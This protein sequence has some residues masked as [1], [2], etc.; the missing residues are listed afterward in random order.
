[1]AISAVFQCIGGVVINILK[2]VIDELER[3]Q[4]I[5]AASIAPYYV[6]SYAC[7]AFS[8]INQ[9]TEAYTEGGMVSKLRMH[10]LFLC[11]PGFG[12]TYMLRQMGDPMYG[13]FG[14]T[15]FS[16]QME[17]NMTE[18][19]LVGSIRMRPD[20]GTEILEGA[21]Y[22]HQNGF[23]LIDEFSAIANAMKQSF[24][25]QLETQ[26][27]TSLDSG[28]VIK[29]LSNGRI[30]YETNFT[31]WAGVQPVKCDLS[32]GLGRRLFSIL[33]LPDDNMRLRYLNGVQ[34]S[35]NIDPGVE[36]LHR[37]RD[38]INL[39]TNSFSMVR[40]ITVDP[41]VF[42]FYREIKAN[43]FDAIMYNR[44][45]LGLTLAR[46]GVS[47][48]INLVFDNVDDMKIIKKQMMWRRMII[49]GPEIHQV[50]NLILNHGIWNGNG[51]VAIN[52]NSLI[53]KGS[54][55]Q[56][57]ISDMNK[58]IKDLAKDYQIEVTKSEI[59]MPLKQHETE[60]LTLQAANASADNPYTW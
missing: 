25:S 21:A 39:W 23:V 8:I 59:V 43:S 18:S 49:E 56:M 20:G 40:K 55:V 45:L 22:E 57:G 41:S 1:M 32:S 33:M 47:R 54:L 51:H 26:L 5:D 58:R 4:V 37:M 9:Q 19:G 30:D 36:H 35:M 10:I 12:K 52:R 24:N 13:I 16:M 38:R 50:R 29:R 44:L 14:G 28:H 60:Y 11:P 48:E 42:D 17:Q 46:R 31:L 27:L 3:R 15:N 34:H 2:D 7:H 6:A 53:D